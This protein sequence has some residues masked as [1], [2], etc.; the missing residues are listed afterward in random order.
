MG[1]NE[2]ESGLPIVSKET[3]ESLLSEKDKDFIVREVYKNLQKDNPDLLL[4]IKAYALRS[5]DPENVYVSSF[6]AYYLL[7]KQSFANKMN[8]E[9]KTD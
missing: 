2:T 6:V 8:K 7:D 1:K 3:I 9:I 4:L 5:K